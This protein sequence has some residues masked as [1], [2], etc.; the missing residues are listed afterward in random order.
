MDITEARAIYRS[1]FKSASQLTKTIDK[2]N[3]SSMNDKDA[4]ELKMKLASQIA[5]IHQNIG[6]IILEK[7]PEIQNEI[8]EELEKHGKLLD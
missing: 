4:K 3:E 6:L 5:S 1:V 2:V 8:D 7:F